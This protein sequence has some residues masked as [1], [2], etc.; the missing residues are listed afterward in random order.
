MD[1][2]SQRNKASVCEKIQKKKLLVIELEPA[3]YKFDLWNAFAISKRCDVN[4]IFTAAK[5]W[6]PD[7]GHNFQELPTALFPF[8]IFHGK[9]IVSFLKSSF[10]FLQYFFGWRPDFVFISGYVDAVPLMAIIACVI[11]KRK[12]S[13]H[14]DI[15][16]NSPPQNIIDDFKYL[17]R[18]L[19]RKLIFRTSV[20]VLNCGKIG[21]E[22]AIV[23]GCGRNKVY[24][25]PYV[26]DPE[27]LR[28]DQPSNVPDV[29]KSDLES[30]RLIIL[31]SGRLIHR[32]G[33]DTLLD[34]AEKLVEINNWVLWIEGDGPLMS[35]YL[36]RATDLGISDK[37]RFLGFCQMS[38]HSWLL[39]NSDIVVIPSIRDPWGIVVDEGMQLGKV[40]ITSNNVAS[41]VDR[42]L[43]GS[44]GLFFPVG[45]QQELSHQLYT[46]LTNHEKR[47]T[48]GDSAQLS[49]ARYGPKENVHTAFQFL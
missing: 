7:G 39:R 46:V 41:G 22:S 35:T 27:R 13:V 43:N 40:V 45:N 29:C 19:I 24:D 4:V 6:A 2:Q 15:F 5:N 34:A 1:N 42:I 44:N 37:C 18:N 25:F 8:E 21:C 3:P 11:F 28:S 26:V 33:L 38:L 49:A 14:S 16:N 20:A 48:L 36:C 9:G 10:V 31:F 47:T 32:K 12:Y 17:F 23:A 30:G